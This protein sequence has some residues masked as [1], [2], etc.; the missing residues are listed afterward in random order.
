MQ[1]LSTNADTVNISFIMETGHG[2]KDS[3]QDLL[4][5]DFS[6]SNHAIDNQ[7][8]NVNNAREGSKNDF[9][10]PL[11]SYASVSAATSNF[12]AGNKLGEG[13]FG[14]VYKVR[15]NA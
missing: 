15:S 3:S 8:K 7:V 6:S 4:S 9:D 5:F 10:L 13:G 1:D 14:P 11:F 12:S 2:K